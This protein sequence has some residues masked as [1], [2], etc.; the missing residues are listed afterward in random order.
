MTPHASQP[1]PDVSYPCRWRYQ[2]MGASEEGVREAITRAAA[3]HEHSV[4]FSRRSRTGRYCSFHLELIVVDEAHRD[5]V[6]RALR[7][8]RDVQFVL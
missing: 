4:T 3:G 1:G 7:D 6:F 5:D 2:V 8:H